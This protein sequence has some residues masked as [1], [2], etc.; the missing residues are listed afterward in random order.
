LGRPSK[1]DREAI[2]NA[3]EDAIDCL[4][5][6]VKGELQKVMNRLHSSR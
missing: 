6:I 5:E 2:D 3:I 4:D 1:D